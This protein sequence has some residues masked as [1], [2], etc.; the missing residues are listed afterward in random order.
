M[1]FEALALGAFWIAAIKL[2]VLDGP[3]FPLAFI[4][5]WLIAFLTIRWV[6][7]PGV[8]FVVL[9]CLLAVLLFLIDRYKAALL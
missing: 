8:A 1:P 9:E 5:L 2:W 6:H 7:W 4:A 3:K